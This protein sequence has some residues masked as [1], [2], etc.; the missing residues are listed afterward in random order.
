MGCIGCEPSLAVKNHLQ[1]IWH[2]VKGVGQ[3]PRFVVWTMVR[4]TPCEVTRTD[5]LCRVDDVAYR[6]QGP[7]CQEEAAYPGQEQHQGQPQQELCPQAFQCLLYSFQGLHHLQPP[8]DAAPR[9]LNSLSVKTLARFPSGK[10]HVATACL[11]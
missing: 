8:D 2:L 9:R 6:P 11:A 3:A 7:I 4:N 1:A 5:A 10:C